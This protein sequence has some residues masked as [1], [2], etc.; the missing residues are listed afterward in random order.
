MGRKR[1][2]L[3]AVIAQSSPIAHTTACE[4]VRLP[5]LLCEA[6]TDHVKAQRESEGAKLDYAKCDALNTVSTAAAL[7]VKTAF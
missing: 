5:A 1:L 4:D 6:L 7:A 2:V 3:T